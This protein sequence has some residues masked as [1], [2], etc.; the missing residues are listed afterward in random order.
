M[1]LISVVQT[2]DTIGSTAKINLGDRR[3]LGVDSWF[4]C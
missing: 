3:G 4:N 2:M 1:K